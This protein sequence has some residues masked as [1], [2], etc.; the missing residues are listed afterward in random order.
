[1]ISLQPYRNDDDVRDLIAEHLEAEN[2]RLADEN[3]RLRDENHRLRIIGG[4]L[5]QARMP[6]T[7]AEIRKLIVDLSYENHRMQAELL[8][9]LKIRKVVIVLVIA[10]AL[11][12]LARLF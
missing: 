1:M 12:P 11:L 2:E 4:E 3:E 6:Q 8:A 9:L 7:P 10:L 5:A